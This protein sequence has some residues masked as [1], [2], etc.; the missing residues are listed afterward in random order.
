M[1]EKTSRKA[2]SR[3]KPIVTSLTKA[4]Y[5]GNKA[6]YAGFVI[7]AMRSPYDGKMYEEFIC[8]TF[9]ETPKPNVPFWY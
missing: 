4:I 9:R 8:R 3:A 1:H 2:P 7:N 5:V 6:E